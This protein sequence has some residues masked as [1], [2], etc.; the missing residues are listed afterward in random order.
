MGLKGIAQCSTVETLHGHMALTLKLAKQNKKLISRQSSRLILLLLN[1]EGCVHHV[2][3][4]ELT[5]KA[6]HFVY[7][8]TRYM[9][10]ILKLMGREG[11]TCTMFQQSYVHIYMCIMVFLKI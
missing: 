10:G 1:T 4:G 5:L 3:K 2:R 7:E 9:Y 6:L 8:G 11:Y